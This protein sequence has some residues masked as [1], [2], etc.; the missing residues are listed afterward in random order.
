MNEYCNIYWQCFIK[1][2]TITYIEESQLFLACNLYDKKISPMFFG[3]IFWNYKRSNDHEWNEHHTV[4]FTYMC[5]DYSVF[6][7][8]F[9]VFVNRIA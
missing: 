3:V 1:K 9:L 7:C 5:L 8:V 6:Y 2:L 4:S